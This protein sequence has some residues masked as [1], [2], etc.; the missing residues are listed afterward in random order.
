[1]VFIQ[2]CIVHYLA[3]DLDRAP[4]DVLFNSKVQLEFC[5][6]EKP[7]GKNSIVTNGKMPFVWCGQIRRTVDIENSN[8]DESHCA[9]ILFFQCGVFVLSACAKI[10]S[11]DAT[12][13]EEWW[14]APHTITIRV[15]EEEQ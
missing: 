6:V 13:T 12:K 3:Y 8:E 2:T 5:C 4:T 15:E 1:M 9:K 11:H 10:S 7:P 14:W